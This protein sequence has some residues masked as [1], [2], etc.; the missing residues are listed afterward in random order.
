MTGRV[1][2]LFSIFGA[3]FRFLVVVDPYPESKSGYKESINEVYRNKK[4]PI[5]TL[6]VW[7]INSGKVIFPIEHA[8]NR[9]ESDRG[10]AVNQFSCLLITFGGREWAGEKIQC[11][12]WY[13]SYCTCLRPY[14]YLQSNVISVD[15]EKI[16]LQSYRI[17]QRDD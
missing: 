3:D 11:I 6:S 12:C 9:S 1:V 13:C 15:F 10:F 5:Q 7:R 14:S 16:C 4:V 2:Y 17:L 8:Q